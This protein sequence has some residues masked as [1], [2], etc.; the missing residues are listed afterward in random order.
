MDR[1]LAL[2]HL[3]GLDPSRTTITF[4]SGNEVR[5]G[6]VRHVDYVFARSIPGAN[7]GRDVTASVAATAIRR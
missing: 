3:S 5:V 2:H 7:H 6:L 1:S 4:T